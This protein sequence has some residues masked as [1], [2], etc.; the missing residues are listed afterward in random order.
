MDGNNFGDVVA[1]E[2]CG[3]M[4]IGVELLTV[5]WW[6]SHLATPRIKECLE[7]VVGGWVNALES[8]CTGGWVGQCFTMRRPSFATV[9]LKR[10]RDGLPLGVMLLSNIENCLQLLFLND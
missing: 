5:S 3:K 8:G 6:F 10:E 4:W 1:G 9:F 7:R 2:I